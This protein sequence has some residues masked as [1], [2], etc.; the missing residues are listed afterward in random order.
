ALEVEDDVDARVGAELVGDGHRPAELLR[1]NR[2]NDVPDA[3]R[4]A[5]VRVVNRA[6]VL[7]REAELVERVLTGRVAVRVARARDGVLN[8]AVLGE[9]LPVV[10]RRLDALRR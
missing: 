7:R 2:T 3:L 9:S 1:A 6:R 5:G 8:R 4:G 10:L